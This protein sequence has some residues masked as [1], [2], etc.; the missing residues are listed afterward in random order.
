LTCFGHNR[1]RC[2]EENK[3]ID[4]NRR[5]GNQLDEEFIKPGNQQM[6][7]YKKTGEGKYECTID[8]NGL[9]T[10][11]ELNKFNSRWEEFCNSDEAISSLIKRIGN[12]LIYPHKS[13][14]PTK[15]DKR[16]SVLMLFGNSALHSLRDD[17][18]F[19]YEGIG[20][21][22][23]FWKVFR[24]LG[25]IDIDSDPETI[26]QDFFNLWYES[27]FRLGLD[28]IYTFPTPASNPQKWATE[29]GL[30]RLFRKKAMEIMFA[31]EK[32]RVLPLIK[33]FVKDRGAV[34]AF[35]KNAYN[36]V[37][38]NSYNLNRARNFEL[39]SLLDDSI[40]IYGTP[41]TRLLYSRIMKEMLR[42]I[43]EEILR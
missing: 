4:K 16:P 10:H 26:K 8:L 20:T 40:R 41:P 34:I 37:A 23:R 1:L 6:I 36:A 22:H 42:N 11:E 5:R 15:I 35:Q 38:K 3:K 2:G 39:K 30:E 27:P 28:V 9:F 31:S 13:W 21:E 18:Y 33:E 17:I 32:T 43:K 7:T 19:S 25:Y 24:E 29:A 14:I 12:T